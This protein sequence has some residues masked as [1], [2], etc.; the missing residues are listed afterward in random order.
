MKMLQLKS[1]LHSK[2]IL[3]PDR[4]GVLFKQN[5]M[6]SWLIRYRRMTVLQILKHFRVLIIQMDETIFGS[7]IVNLTST[8]RTEKVGE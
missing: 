5:V 1:I 6:I 3:L 8:I 2:W 4:R 7:C